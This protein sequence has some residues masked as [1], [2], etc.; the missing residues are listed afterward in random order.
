[1]LKRLTRRELLATTG[2]AV[3]AATVAGSAARAADPWPSKPIRVIMPFGA[4]GSMDI[5]SRLLAPIVSEALGQPVVV[6]NRAGATG[7]LAW[8]RWQRLPRMVTR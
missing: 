6:E 3:A 2:S 4:G 7:T 8:R 5:L 1:M